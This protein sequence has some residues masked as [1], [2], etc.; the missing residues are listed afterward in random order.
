MCKFSHH[1][2]YVTHQL[3]VGVARRFVG[4]AFEIDADQSSHDVF[5]ERHL[6]L[7]T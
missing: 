2:V 5:H 1:V 7:R 4:W 3:A 6:Y